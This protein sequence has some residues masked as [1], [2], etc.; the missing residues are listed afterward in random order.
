MVVAECNNL[1][2]P[3]IKRNNKK[4]KKG[5]AVHTF[6]GSLL[7]EIDDAAASEDKLDGGLGVGARR[8]LSDTD[9]WKG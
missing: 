7:E 4:K 5:I 8:K 1:Q 9:I 6:A 2:S 3:Q